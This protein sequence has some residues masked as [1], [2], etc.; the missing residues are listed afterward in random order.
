MGKVL[1]L[2]LIVSLVFYT[3]GLSLNLEAKSSSLPGE[4]F[5]CAVLNCHENYMSSSNS[6]QDQSH[7]TSNS[8]LR[9]INGLKVFIKRPISS[10]NSPE[11]S[12]HLLASLTLHE[13]NIT[14]VSNG[15]K[16]DGHLEASK[17][18]VRVE[19]FKTNDCTAEFFCEVFSQDIHGNNIVNRNSLQLQ[20]QKQNADY[21]RDA[22]GSGIGSSQ[23]M[24]LFQQ[25][26]NNYQLSLL[27]NRLEDRMRSIENRIFDKLCQLEAK[28]SPQSDP[29]K[30]TPESKN[31]DISQ[32]ITN[33][34]EKA[35]DVSKLMKK[36]LNESFA[37]VYRHLKQLQIL[38][39]TSKVDS[40]N[41]NESE[42]VDPD[43]CDKSTELFSSI[44]DQISLTQKVINNTMQ[45]I[46]DLLMPKRCQEGLV[47][48]SVQ[49]P[50]PY[51]VIRPNKESALNVSY[52]CDE[53][54]DG[55][56]W[57][58]IQRRT[59]GQEVFYRDWATYRRGFGSLTGDFWI[60]NKNLY[61]LTNGGRYELRVDLKYN[62]KSV[63]AHYTDFSIASEDDNYRMTYGAYDGTAGDALARQKGMQF[64]T[65]DRDNDIQP[66]QHCARLY[67]GAW[68]YKDCH[69][70][71]LNGKWGEKQYKGPRWGSFTNDEPASFTEMKIRLMK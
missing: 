61:F 4:R 33:E 41:L 57:I 18:S 60:G 22:V 3:S 19:L 53:T 1:I 42:K 69:D 29:P 49:G 67:I 34:L 12:S 5:P 45:P 16:F 39:V 21:W 37:E 54:T 71:N 24:M 7:L 23:S 14:R 27:E 35:L 26:S 68:W 47:S 9:T 2:L 25:L 44:H 56:G 15:M 8:S 31:G 58:V 28:L 65:F 59:T 13:P 11:I 64:S 70:S 17:A 46:S 10:K 38:N 51:P 55:G 52:L 66:S 6:G 62:G 50:F 40:L 48:F 30:T 43:T 20:Q 32:R 36:N 63:F